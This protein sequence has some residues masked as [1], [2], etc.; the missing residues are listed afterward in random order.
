[1]ENKYYTPTRE[2]V[3]PE[4]HIVSKEDNRFCIAPYVHRVGDY[5]VDIK[6][7]AAIDNFQ[8]KYLDQ[9]DIESL[10]WVVRVVEKTFPEIFNYKKPYKDDRKE[11]NIA[12]IFYNSVSKWGLI[13]TVNSKNEALP[14]AHS[15]RFS[16]YIKNKSE[17]KRLMDMLQ[18]NP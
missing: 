7:T 9:S 4:L 6:K 10:G 5:C 1:M 12:C 16:G 11:H 17:L 8:I 13:T 18:I 15:T 14:Y 2:E 3:Y